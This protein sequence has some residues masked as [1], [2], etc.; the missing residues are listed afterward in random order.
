M[1]YKVATLNTTPAYDGMDVA[2][3]AA[4]T[5]TVAMNNSADVDI[6]V[7]GVTDAAG[8]TLVLEHFQ[9]WAVG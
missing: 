4:G 3:S 2:G 8:T 7:T 5:Y 9:V 6:D 1:E